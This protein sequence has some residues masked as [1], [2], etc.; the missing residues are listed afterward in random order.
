MLNSNIHFKDLRIF[1]IRSG[2]GAEQISQQKA[3]LNHLGKDELDEKLSIKHGQLLIKPSYLRSW[4][5]L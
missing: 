2:L 1:V 5:Q 3:A 4:K